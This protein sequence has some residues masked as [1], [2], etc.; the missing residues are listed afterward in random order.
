MPKVTTNVYLASSVHHVQKWLMHLVK[1]IRVTSTS[2][3]RQ[4]MHTAVLRQWVAG[5]KVSK[6]VKTVFTST[7]RKKPSTTSQSQLTLATVLE[8]CSVDGRVVVHSILDMAATC[9]LSS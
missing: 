5:K 6:D 8:V 4:A 9:T 3:K 7:T 2:L 1:M